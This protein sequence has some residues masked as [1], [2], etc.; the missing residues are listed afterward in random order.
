MKT[1]NPSTHQRKV[2]KHRQRGQGMAEYII[3]V[4]LV[5]VAGITTWELVGSSIGQSAAGVAAAIGGTDGS[6][7]R[8]KATGSAEAAANAA[9]TRENLSN[10]AAGNNGGG[11]AGNAGNAGAPNT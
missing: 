6:A 3:I 8:T 9:D 2:G 10:Y 1:T 5:A 11:N 7:E 4:A